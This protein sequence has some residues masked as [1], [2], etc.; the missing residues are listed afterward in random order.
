[1]INYYNVIWLFWKRQ[2]Y[3]VCR[4]L[5]MT[6]NRYAFSGKFVKPYSEKWLLH[7]E[8]RRKFHWN[9]L[10][11]VSVIIGKNLTNDK[12]F[13]Y[14]RVSYILIIDAEFIIF[15]FL[16]Y[17]SFQ[18]LNTLID[19]FKN[20][21]IRFSFFSINIVFKNFNIRRGLQI[22]MLLQGICIEGKYILHI[23]ITYFLSL[24]YQ[25]SYLSLHIYYFLVCRFFFWKYPR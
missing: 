20:N 19:I 16:Y 12:I 8:I 9:T 22:Y 25:K 23:I 6:G 21:K 4:F 1:M 13:K 14:L 3:L 7:K 2:S 10:T 11:S 17:S 5:S 15:S 18:F 24:I